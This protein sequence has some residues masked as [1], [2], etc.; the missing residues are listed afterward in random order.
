MGK[1]IRSKND[2]EHQWFIQLENQY[3]HGDMSEEFYLL[4]LEQH[5]PNYYS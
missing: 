1:I 3:L 2:K 4:Q 5:C